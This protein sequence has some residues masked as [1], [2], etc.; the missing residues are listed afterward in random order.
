MFDKVPQ[1][2]RN[3][4]KILTHFRQLKSD[5]NRSIQKFG[6]VSFRKFSP[7]FLKVYCYKTSPKHF[8]I[9]LIPNTRDVI[10]SRF[11][12]L[13]W[14]SFIRTG[15]SDTASNGIGTEAEPRL[16]SRPAGVGREAA[17]SGRDVMLVVRR[18]ERT[19]AKRS[20][21]KIARL[22]RTFSCQNRILK[23][24]KLLLIVSDHQPKFHRYLWIEIFINWWS[25]SYRS[26]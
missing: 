26:I 24:R 13:C 5:P 4:W 23:S 17:R 11:E 15:K 2:L 19:Q 14:R 25:P 20:S 8:S 16:N 7:K 1:T 3:Y 12:P 22:A 9:F 10:L 18:G 6:I 21:Q